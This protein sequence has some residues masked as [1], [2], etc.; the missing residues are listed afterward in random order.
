MWFFCLSQISICQFLDYST[1]PTD[2]RSELEL[3]VVHLLKCTFPQRCVMCEPETTSTAIQC[4][5]QAIIYNDYCTRSI[6]TSRLPKCPML[7][8]D[9]LARHSCEQPIN[10]FNSSNLS[11]KLNNN[12]KH[13]STVRS[14]DSPNAQ[15]NGQDCSR[16]MMNN[17]TRTPDSAEFGLKRIMHPPANQAN[18]HHH[19]TCPQTDHSAVHSHAFSSYLLNSSSSSSSGDSPSSVARPTES[20]NAT[21]PN[22]RVK[23]LNYNL[24]SSLSSSIVILFCLIQLIANG[25]NVLAASTA[26]DYQNSN[27]N[28]QPDKDPNS[29]VYQGMCASSSSS[30]F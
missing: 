6:C 4:T 7:E 11:T 23:K 27:P 20:T 29:I 10:L 8:F 14:P 3:C 17:P 19:R 1:R 18:N 24:S 30:S 22:L 12:F 5:N 28:N 13:P 25:T 26:F 9:E 2:E 16:R 21:K 15:A